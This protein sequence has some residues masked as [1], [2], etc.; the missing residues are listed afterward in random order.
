[1]AKQIFEWASLLTWAIIVGAFL[2]YGTLYMLNVVGEHVTTIPKLQDR[3]P[4]SRSSY[5]LAVVR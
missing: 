2:G 5:H 1:M 3:F 4:P